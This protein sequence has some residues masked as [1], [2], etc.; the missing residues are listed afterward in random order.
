MLVITYPPQDGGELSCVAELNL[1]LVG[2]GDAEAVLMGR[3]VNVSDVRVGRLLEGVVEDQV[4]ERLL[5]LYASAACI[6]LL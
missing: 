4:P 6:Y 3:G 2:A 5:F 1:F